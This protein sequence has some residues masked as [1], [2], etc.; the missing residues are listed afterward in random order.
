MEEWFYAL[1]KAS[2]L[3]SRP[4]AASTEQRTRT[5]F[6]ELIARLGLYHSKAPVD[7]V[8]LNAVTHR[9]FFHLHNDPGL[10]H[11]YH[12]KIQHKF[13]KVKKPSMV[14]RFHSLRYY[15][16]T[17]THTHMCTLI[18]VGIGDAQVYLHLQKSVKVLDLKFGTNL[19][20]FDNVQLTSV[21]PEGELVRFRSTLIDPLRST[22]LQ[23][24]Q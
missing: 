19:P 16:H 5:F 10:I 7:A 11:K 21:S 12:E 6:R 4:E 13:D 18:R 1:N 17:H 20:L 15:T 24:R 9:I 22:P 8:W 2:V 3:T 14:V 23:F